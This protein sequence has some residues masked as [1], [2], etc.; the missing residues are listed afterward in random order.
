VAN[1][2]FDNLRRDQRLGT[3]FQVSALIS[4]GFFLFNTQMHER[5]VHPALLFSGLFALITGRCNVFF[6]ITVGYLLNLEAVMRYMR[7]FDEQWLGFTIDYDRIFLFEP[8]FV[9]SI[10][11]VAYIY[12]AIE[13]Y[14]TFFSFRTS[15]EDSSALKNG[16]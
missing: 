4:L 11:M 13:F 7:Y 9:A 14:R 5:Y 15:E 16:G 1:G 12:G 3:V 8:K 6:L 2:A 10:F